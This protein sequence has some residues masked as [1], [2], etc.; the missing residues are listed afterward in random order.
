MFKRIIIN[1]KTS[2]MADTVVLAKF[3]SLI[4]RQDV[5][6]KLHETESALIT[7]THYICLARKTKTGTLSFT[8]FNRK[9]SENE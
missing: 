5:M 3:Y 1:N 6:D 7:Y 4:T 9:R 2:D 8:F